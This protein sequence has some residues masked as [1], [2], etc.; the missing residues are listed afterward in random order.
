MNASH[1]VVLVGGDGVELQLAHVAGEFL[2]PVPLHVRL[3]A[4][5]ILVG[6]AAEVAYVR[7][8]PFVQDEMLL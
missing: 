8:G 2:L 6:V 5:G 3:E 7:T 4:V 1:A